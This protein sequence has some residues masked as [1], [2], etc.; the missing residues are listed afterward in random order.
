MWVTIIALLNRYLSPISPVVTYELG[1]TMNWEFTDTHILTE[2]NSG[3]M[4]CLLSGSW[5][6]VQE[7]R[8]IAPK[9]IAFVEQSL[10]L[11]EGLDFAELNAY[12]VSDMITAGEYAHNI[13]AFN[14]CR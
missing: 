12:R 3:Y 10:L 5:L 1:H 11:R 2:T 7:V 4:L 14:Q 6:D 9:G 8:P 13:I